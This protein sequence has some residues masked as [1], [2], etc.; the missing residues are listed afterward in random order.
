MSKKTFQLVTA[1]IT[2]VSTIASA[3]V[4]HV[5]P[6]MAVAIVAG[7]EVAAGAAIEICSLFIPTDKKVEATK[8]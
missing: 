5:A 1:V 2:G 7:I 4:V 6:P 3:V 8:Q